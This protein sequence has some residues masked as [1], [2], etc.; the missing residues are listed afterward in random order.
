MYRKTKLGIIISAAMLATGCGG[1]S[2][3]SGSGNG[4]DSGSDVTISGRAA[5]GYLVQANVCAD[6]NGNAQCDAG[7][8]NAT[9]GAGG[10]FELTMKESELGS[11]LVVEA[12]A[13][14]TVDEDTNQPVPDNFTLRSPIVEEQDQQFVSPVT[15]MVTTAMT[16][17]TAKALELAKKAV[18]E[19]LGS[20]FDPMADYVAAKQSGNETEKQ[21]AERLHRIA[22]VTARMMA[23]IEKGVDQSELDK[24][25]MT[26]AEFLDLASNALNR[27]APL[28]AMQV[29]ETMGN[30]DF[31][32]DQIADAPELDIDAP[33]DPDEP[34]AINEPSPSNDAL[35]DRVDAA[36]PGNPYFQETANGLEAVTGGSA[37]YL[38]FTKSE[39]EEGQYQM[40]AVERRL[41]QGSGDTGV[42]S[43]MAGET[44]D[45]DGTV[46]LRPIE[47]TVNRVRMFLGGEHIPRMINDSHL[48][49]VYVKAVAAG[50]L[51]GAAYPSMSDEAG[52]GVQFE[53][54][55]VDLSRL[56]IK[57]I[58]PMLYPSIEAGSFSEIPD[59]TIFP[60]GAA[61]F[62]A[63]ETFADPQFVTS[64]H[65]LEG[66]DFE[67]DSHCGP[68]AAITDVQ[69]CN[70][71]YGNHT[72]SGV[73]APAPT[74]DALT[75]DVA[76]FEN[77]Q[78][79]PTTSAG[80]AFESNGQ[81]YVMYVVGNPDDGSGQVAIGRE[82]AKGIVPVAPGTWTRESQP[83]EHIRLDLP[84]GI[85]YT[86]FLDATGSEGYP[87]LHEYEGYVRA[88]WA[89]PAGAD[90]AAH[91]D[92]EPGNMLLNSKAMM[93]VMEKLMDWNKLAAH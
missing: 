20:S 85:E 78:F 17:D 18:A 88:G 60:D 52:A 42:L 93:A 43:A 16:D 84:D 82:D 76:T 91:F 61:A 90:V 5:D 1:S 28:I 39:T 68:H 9:T 77:E 56:S 80:I 32:P 44:R 11:S 92:R 58:L 75:Y 45:I 62:M 35:A 33:V 86:A 65:G 3:S 51:T 79:D 12:I 69:S 57:E 64:W 54:S 87:F 38:N 4:A 29:D 23:K 25:G 2:S 31:D 27:I 19:R 49:S 53:Y 83:F 63:V 89:T 66:S 22:Q 48:A 73:P 7:E 15:T 67:S 59:D 34:P 26:K 36:T 41:A 8:P 71:V 74:L 30:P 13:N 47:P 50:S 40:E 37:T 72:V 14:L 10:V 81:S 6:L 46:T 21:N 70:V 55:Q 24:A